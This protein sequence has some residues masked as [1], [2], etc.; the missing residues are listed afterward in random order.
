MEKRPKLDPTKR[1]LLF[2]VLV[3]IMLIIMIDPLQLFSPKA[4]PGRQ[5]FNDQDLATAL[6]SF[7]SEAKPAREVVLALF[8]DRQVVLV[9]THFLVKE[10]LDFIATL[11]PELRGAGV[12]LI[13]V[14]FL[15]AIDQPNI[16][17]LVQSDTFDESQARQLIFN[18]QVLCGYQENVAVLRAVWKANHGR[19]AGTA[20]LRLIGLNVEQDLSAIKSQDDAKNPAVMK[21]V[22]AKGVPDAYMARQVMRA[23]GSAGKMLVV[24]QIQSSLTSWPDRLY[25]ADITQIGFGGQNRLGNTL[26]GSLSDKIAT[27]LLSGPWPWRNA[28]TRTAFPVDGLV[29]RLYEKVPSEIQLPQPAA[30]ALSRAALGSALCQSSDFS[31][32]QVPKLKELGAVLVA[33]GPVRTLHAVTPIA[34]FITPANLGLVARKM[35]AMYNPGQLSADKLNE[36]IAKVNT[37]MQSQLESFR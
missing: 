24:T 35:P 23:C 17:S 26:Y 13:G 7:V 3:V 21:K 30:W 5:N 34:N 31:A 28:P 33:F 19:L 1:K 4:Q 37:D 36:S 25:S 16:D 14:E 8:R 27:V 18:W 9:G 22:F 6:P 20:P 32:A 10:H 29:D 11:V 2:G 15:K 12:D